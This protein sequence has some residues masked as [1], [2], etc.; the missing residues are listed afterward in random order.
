MHWNSSC[1]HVCNQIT[2][3]LGARPPDSWLPLTQLPANESQTSTL[4][5]RLPR[6]YTD[7]LPT[8]GQHHQQWD[9]L[10]QQWKPHHSLNIENDIETLL[11]FFRTF[12]DSW[13]RWNSYYIHFLLLPLGWL[14]F[15]HA[16]KSWKQTYFVNI[17]LSIGVIET[18]KIM[19][20]FSLF[21]FENN[22]CKFNWWIQKFFLLLPL[23]YLNSVHVCKIQ[24]V[25]V[26]FYWRDIF[27][28]F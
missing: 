19:I 27:F 3:L 23:G 20:S 11:S 16:C 1:A 15:I 2:F 13:N 18:F 26:L 4:S 8:Q 24:F 14:N 22:N 10:F 17:I 12:Q 5:L 28:D 25:A 6:E 21:F 7:S 9:S